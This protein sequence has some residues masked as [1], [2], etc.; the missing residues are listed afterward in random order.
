MVDVDFSQPLGASGRTTLP[1][2]PLGLPLVLLD[3]LR[4]YKVNQEEKR[5]ADV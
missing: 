1:I 3:L 4:G 2:V 5:Y